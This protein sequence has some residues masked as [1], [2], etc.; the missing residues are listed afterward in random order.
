[1]ESGVEVGRSGHGGIPGHHQRR[2]TNVYIR[3]GRRWKIVH[4]TRTDVSADMLAILQ[5]L[6]QGSLADLRAG[7]SVVAASSRYKNVCRTRASR[8]PSPGRQRLE[9]L[10]L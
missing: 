6:Q 1:M 5:R 7:A 9:H 3:A 10:A 8:R 4:R 2:V